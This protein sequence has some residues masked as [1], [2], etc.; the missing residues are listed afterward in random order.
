MQKAEIIH[1]INNNKSGDFLI[2]ESDIWFMNQKLKGLIFSLKN[3]NRDYRIKNPYE[4]ALDLI[5]NGDSVLEVT[6]IEWDKYDAFT[7]YVDDAGRIG[8]YE[9]EFDK[10]AKFNENN[11]GKQIRDIFFKVLPL[12]H[13]NLID[14]VK[15]DTLDEVIKYLGQMVYKNKLRDRGLDWEL[16]DFNSSGE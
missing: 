11:L 7:Y 8:F 6:V 1:K 3:E 5:R 4:V 16:K 2:A 10:F 14:F 9:E 12:E 13:S 15:F